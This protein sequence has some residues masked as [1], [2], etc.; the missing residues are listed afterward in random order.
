LQKKDFNA[1]GRS[2]QAPTASQGRTLDCFSSFGLEFSSMLAKRGWD[3]N[4]VV[5]SIIEDVLIF[6]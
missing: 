6:I 4:S 2:A 1:N 5:S 3:I